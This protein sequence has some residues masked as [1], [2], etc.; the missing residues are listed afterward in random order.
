MNK[1]LSFLASVF[2]ASFALGIA[3]AGTA[4]ADNG[5]DTG[6]FRWLASAGMHIGG[7]LCNGPPPCPDAALESDGGDGH[8]MEI[9]G[10]GRLS[11]RKGKRRKISGG[12]SYRQTD[13]MGMLAGLGVGTWTAEKLK[14]FESFG[15]STATDFPESFEQG[16]AI[17]EIRMVSESGKKA[18]ATLTLGCLLPEPF[19]KAPDFVIEGIRLSVKGKGG[20]DFDMAPPLAPFPAHAPNPDGTSTTDR[21]TL[22]IRLP[23]DGRRRRR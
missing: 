14:S 17:I 3:G 2:L 6:E 19:M 10:E 8:L 9:V 7:F 1:R 18:K 16:Q 22:F 5:G 21:A 12:G 15:P 4:Y 11:I 13:M 23:D 20:Q